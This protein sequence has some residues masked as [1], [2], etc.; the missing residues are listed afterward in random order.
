[1]DKNL[2]E[3]VEISMAPSINKNRQD[4]LTLLLRAAF[5]SLVSL[6]LVM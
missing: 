4:A 5:K 1:M 2:W 3:I 6:Q